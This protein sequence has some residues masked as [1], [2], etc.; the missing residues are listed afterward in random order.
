VQGDGFTTCADYCASIG[1]TCAQ[2]GC[3]GGF[4]LNAWAEDGLCQMDYSAIGGF[5]T[6]PC[7]AA[8]GWTVG[9]FSH[10]RCCCTDTH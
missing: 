10:I 8:I 4:T 3:A 6:G 5:S 9:T 2:A 1:E 7:G